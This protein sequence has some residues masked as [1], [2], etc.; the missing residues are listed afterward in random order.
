MHTHIPDAELARFAIDPESIPADRRE[1]IEQAAAQCADCRGSLDFF[2][3][4]TAEDL[5]DLEMWEPQVDWASDD[6]LRVYAERIEAEDREADALLTAE[7]LLDSPAKIVWKN[8]QRNKRFLSGGIVRRLT[9]HAHSICEQEPL[10]ATMFADTAISIAE[11]M[12]DDTYPWN[13]IYELRGTAWKERA[14]AL[15][16][17]GELPSALDALTHAERAYRHLKSAGLGLSTVALVRASVLCEQDRLDEAAA[18]AEKAE[19]GFAHIAQEERRTRAVYL[20]GSI[21]YEMGD[22]PTAIRL[23]EQVL[24]YGETQNNAQWIARASYAIGTCEVDR[25]NLA[26]ASMRFHKALVLFREA[27][28]E[29]D[30][31]GAE[32]GLARV[33][34]HGGNTSEAIRR[35]RHVAVE[36]ERIGMITVAALVR[37]D[38]IDALLSLG[39]TKEIVEIASRLFRIF[40]DAGMITGCLTAMAYL[41]EAAAAGRLTPTGVNAV[42]A[43]VR[44]V[45]RHPDLVF[46]PPDS[47][48]G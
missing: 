13:A 43:Y 10:G 3:V 29:R 2:S 32:W 46:E 12:P 11:T 35:L 47:F 4:I 41:K 9:A 38:C 30:R 26:E 20:R 25:R 24:D 34:L 21:T 23:F 42:R 17:R 16:V 15:F 40:K 7:R 19:Q 1:A 22:V 31:L 33:V 6:P 28:P 27:G 44:R 39:Q 48:K 37:L 45:D 8:L 14:N 5:A 18:W 36:C